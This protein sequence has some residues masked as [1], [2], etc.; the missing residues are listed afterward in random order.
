MDLDDILF[1]Y[2]QIKKYIYN[3]CKPSTKMLI[4]KKSS[5]KPKKYEYYKKKVNL[6]TFMVKKNANRI[7]LD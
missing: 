1:L 4:L 3:I 6:L 2:S 5:V 7:N